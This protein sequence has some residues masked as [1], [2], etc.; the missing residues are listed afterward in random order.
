MGAADPTR[1]LLTHSLKRLF[2]PEEY[3]LRQGD[4]VTHTI[5]PASAPCGASL[6]EGIYFREEEK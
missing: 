2:L 4:P 1:S 3:P 5:G 6:A